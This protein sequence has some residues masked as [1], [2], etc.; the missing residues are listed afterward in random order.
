MI[1]SKSLYLEQNN[2]NKIHLDDFGLPMNGIRVDA[3]AWDNKNVV[4][5]RFRN[6]LLDGDIFINGQ[7]V[8]TN[9]AV[10]TQD[11]HIE[12]WRKGKLHRDEGLPAVISSGLKHKEFWVNGKPIQINN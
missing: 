3:N 2:S 1:E 6:G 4:I 8:R 9:P 7:F 10:E 11:G 12:Y 5:L